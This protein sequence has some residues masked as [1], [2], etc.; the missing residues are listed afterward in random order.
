MMRGLARF[1]PNRHHADGGMPRDKRGWRVAP[2]PDG[3]GAPE[4]PAP[5]RPHRS[6]RFV[7]LVVL[8]AL[9]FGSALLV[10]PAGQPR[11]RVPFSPYF[12]SAVQDGRVA[13]IA[14]TGNTIQGTFKAAVRY[15]A[16]DRMAPLTTRFRPEVPTFW[17]DNQPQLQPRT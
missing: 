14:S 12:V 3:R 15:P 4:A 16:P 2:A 5:P 10:R 1:G 7:W 13:L 17:N 8:L 6:R 9:N 11:V